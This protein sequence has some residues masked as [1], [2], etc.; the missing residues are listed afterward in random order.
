[1]PV[2]IFTWVLAAVVLGIC[3]FI[4][5]FSAVGLY[6]GF[7]VPS[8]LRSF[9]YVPEGA[10]IDE[11]KVPRVMHEVVWTGDLENHLLSEASGIARSSLNPGVFFAI[12]DSNNGPEIFALGDDGRDLGFWT[13]DVARNLDWED[14]ASFTLDGEPYLLIADVGDNFRWRP[15][16]E[17]LVVR[18]PDIDELAMDEVIP[19]AWKIRFRY[20]DG[21][22]DSEAVAV[23]E[24]ERAVYVISKRTIP[25]EVYRLPL[26]STQTL[27]TAERVA[28]LDSIPRPNEQDMWEDPCNGD[29]RSMPT[30]FDINRGVAA[31]VT[32]KDAYIYRRGYRESWAE[33]FIGLPERVSLPPV[34]AQEAGLLTK[35][36]RYLYVTSE[37]EDGTERV[38]MFRV[39]L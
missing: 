34:N 25:A 24:Q 36:G 26:E 29:Y 4:A 33:A 19:V 38:G 1:M 12:N 5:G 37:R 21:Y 32:Y 11:G 27:V 2:K 35:D 7:D 22:R 31:V 16:L 20:P 28:M 39:R 30:A 3:L 14:L 10:T 6:H 8:G 18:E 9:L 17:L 23:D 15:V 13:V